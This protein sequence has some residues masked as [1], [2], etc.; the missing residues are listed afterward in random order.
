MTNRRRARE[1]ALQILYQVDLTCSDPKEGW[2]QAVEGS[3]GFVLDQLR[4]AVK[5][6]PA[7]KDFAKELVL[8]VWDNREEIDHLIER[9]SQHWK[10]MRM[11]VVDRNILR[12]AAYQLLYRKDI[13]EK[14]TI[15]EAI[16]LG[17]R[18]GS[19]ESGAFINGILD[20]IREGL[21]RQP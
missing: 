19:E 14:V 1:L 9:T 17:K 7:I 3:C 10:L 6:S 20:K 13:P 21:E 12:L 16:E 5:A 18:F 15:D 11:A 8:G 2:L 4:N